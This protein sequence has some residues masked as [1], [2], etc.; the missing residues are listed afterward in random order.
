MTRLLEGLT[1]LDFTRVYCGPYAT[2]LLAD[3]GA[4]IIKV[5]NP[6]GGD[7]S[8]TFGPLVGRSSGY[9][10][11]LNRGK[12]SIAL[13][14]TQPENQAILRHLAAHVDVLI[15]NARPGVMARY[16]LDYET[17]RVECPH[18]VYVS[19][20][21][22][23]QTGPDASRP[24][25]DIVAQACSG[26]MSLT[27][28]PD[29]PLKT[30]PAIADAIAG[31]TAAVGLLAALWRQTRTGQGAHIDVAMV[32]ALFA[33]LENALV[34]YSVTG[35]VP[36][37]RG[38]I[39]SVVAPFDSFEAT[40][41]LIVIGVG[42]D[43]LW[44]RLARLVG[45]GLDDEARFA[46]NAERIAHYDELRPRLATWCAYQPATVVLEALQAEGIPSGLV[47]SIDDLAYDPHLEVRGMLARLK[48][49][50]D[51]SITVP[52]SPIHVDGTHP[53]IKRAPRLG[54][55]TEDVLKEFGK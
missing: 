34:T 29:Q 18:L 50:D 48:L 33:C 44:N 49:D 32:E 5:E 15:E 11:M 27:G 42:N 22:F 14:V 46:T 26:L 39:D 4:R 31:L 41:G 37:R 23:G 47:R 35:Q 6:A 43:R 13:D 52:G 20:S 12:E 40:D 25:Y 38:N 21:G 36:A 10:E 51:I 3:L 30:G 9:F 19:I 45:N 17:L 24:C 55:H 53:P 8:R 16:G 2:L 1:V 7:D 54:E 28:L